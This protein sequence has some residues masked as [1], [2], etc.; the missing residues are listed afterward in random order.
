VSNDD[1]ASPIIRVFFIVEYAGRRVS[2]DGQRFFKINPV[3]GTVGFGFLWI[4]FKLETHP[5]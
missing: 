5:Q 4:P 1:L 2:K 3:T